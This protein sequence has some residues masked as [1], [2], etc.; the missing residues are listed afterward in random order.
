MT[1]QQLQKNRRFREILT[2][3]RLE[4][5]ISLERSGNRERE[6]ELRARFAEM[7]QTYTPQTLMQE[8]VRRTLHSVNFYGFALNVIT[9]AKRL[10]RKKKK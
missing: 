2:L 7:P 8:G 1:P 3:E 6:E 10:L 5:E 9:I 4:A